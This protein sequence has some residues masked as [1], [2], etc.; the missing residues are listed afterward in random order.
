[1]NRENICKEL[2][3]QFASSQG[4]GGQNI[5]KRETKAQ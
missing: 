3:F 2:V 1:M 4:N 5:N